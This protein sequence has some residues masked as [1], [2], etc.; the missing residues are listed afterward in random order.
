LTVKRRVSLFAGEHWACPAF[1]LSD[2]GVRLA[3]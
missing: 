1:H 2:H 3:E